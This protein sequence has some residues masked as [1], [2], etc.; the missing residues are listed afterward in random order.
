M[1]D[2]EINGKTYKDIPESYSDLNLREFINLSKF[3][4]KNKELSDKEPTKYSVLLL[5]NFIGAPKED[6]YKLNTSHFS[7]LVDFFGW[8]GKMP[9]E[10][11]AKFIKIDGKEYMFKN[12]SDMTAG[13][14]ISIETVK[15]SNEDELDILHIIFAIICRPVVKEG[16]KKV[17]QDLEDSFDDIKKRGELFLDKMIIEEAYGPLQNFTGG[18]TKSSTKTT[19]GSSS[20]IIKRRKKASS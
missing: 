5:E 18:V 11:K 4:N 1:V 15:T 9:K 17:I 8:L 13:E 7:E 20:L 6:I 3:M 16:R 12:L 2:I 14:Q 10:S 19:Q